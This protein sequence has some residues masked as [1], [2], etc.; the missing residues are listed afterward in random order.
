MTSR[1]RQA[2][3]RIHTASPPI[4]SIQDSTGPGSLEVAHVAQ[5][6]AED[7]QGDQQ[8]VN[9]LENPCRNLGRKRHALVDRDQIRP[10]KLSGPAEQGDGREAND[11]GRNQL[12]H[13]GMRPE[14]A[15]AALPTGGPVRSR[16]PAPSPRRPAATP[17]E[18]A[19]ASRRRPTSESRSG[20]ARSAE[21]TAPSRT[22]AAPIVSHFHRLFLMKPPSSGARHT[23]CPGMEK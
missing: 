1:S 20:G 22:K 16:W 18:L 11:G 14:R 13:V 6:E 10:D 3:L 19:S 15:S 4:S 17:V 5:G 21:D 8:V 23:S 2:A 9:P 7:G 12:P